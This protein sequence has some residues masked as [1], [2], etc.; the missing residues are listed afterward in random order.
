MNEWLILSKEL[1]NLILFFLIV[2]ILNR[3]FWCFLLPI[4][5][6][7]LLKILKKHDKRTGALIR[8]PFVQ[9]V[10]QQPFFTT[11]VLNK[12]VKECE[13]MLDHI[14]SK[15][16]PSAPSEATKVEERCESTTVT[17]NRDRI[18]KAP[19]ELA[20]IKQMESVYVK[21]T[22]SALR[23]LK[24]VRSGSSTVSAFSLPPLQINV[25]EEDLKNM[26][27]IEQVAK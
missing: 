23:V 5:S 12:L 2:R 3:A 22:V 20:E 6:T 19:T 21:Q 18:F 11:D 7:G 17:E 24:E 15:N 4:S 14:F 8:L 9:R 10:M 25:V 13:V 16:D 1:V 26:P 27:V